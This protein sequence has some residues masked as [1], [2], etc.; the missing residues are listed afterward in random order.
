MRP[1]TW[2][3]A[4]INKG[5]LYD[6]SGSSDGS[7]ETDRS[8]MASDYHYE[9]K[10]EQRKDWDKFVTN[11]KGSGSASEQ[12]TDFIKKASIGLK[13]L[14]ILV[15]FSATLGG[16]VIAKTALFFMVAQISPSRPIT[17]CKDQAF[18]VT[19]DPKASTAWLWCLFFAFTAP[20]FFTLVRSAR[21]Y[22]MRKT[23]WP[24]KTY[25]AIVWLF[26][27]LH[28]F[29]VALLFFVAL[30]HLDSLRA[31]ILTNGVLFLPCLLSVFKGDSIMLFRGLDFLALL[32]QVGGLIIWPVLNLSWG[33]LADGDFWKVTNSWALPLGLFFASFGWWESFVDETSKFNLTF[34][35]R[36]KIN[37]IEEGTRFTTYLF[38]CIWKVALFFSLF[39]AFTK[40]VSGLAFFLC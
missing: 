31:M 39:V 10:I 24:P 7:E 33:D 12:H 1:R 13:L 15:T 28:T 40:L 37:M 9:R 36:V 5:Y 18:V 32:L 19:Q 14:T 34:L 2:R 8:S 16:G 26:E 25:I 6:D 35:W 20:E 17:Y 22:M 27:T 11:V 38:I 23:S 4:H 29:G 30:P 3:M 21:V